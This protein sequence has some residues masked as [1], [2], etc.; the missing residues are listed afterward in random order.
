MVYS[1]TVSNAGSTTADNVALTNVLPAS[2]S[3]GSITNGGNPVSSNANSSR[4]DAAFDRLEFRYRN[5]LTAG[6]PTVT[7]QV[8]EGGV[9]YRDCLDALRPHWDRARRDAESLP[10]RSSGRR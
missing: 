2:L 10:D 7:G 4:L 1:L 3:Y 6:V 9:G 8:F 5:A